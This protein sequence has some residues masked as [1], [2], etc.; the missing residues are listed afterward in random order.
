[1]FDLTQDEVRR[2]REMEVQAYPS[3]PLVYHRSFG[4]SP[5][6]VAL[7]VAA[8]RTFRVTHV[9]RLSHQRW[10]GMRQGATLSG[11][12]LAVLVTNAHG[13]VDE[14]LLYQQRSGLSRADLLI[15]QPA[16]VLAHMATYLNLR[17]PTEVVMAPDLA[18]EV[19]RL[20]RQERPADGSSGAH[21]GG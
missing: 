12:W 13:W 6:A 18:R 3:R 19:A 7:H 2:A 16:D 20:A 21:S 1:M 14:V 10:H 8:A 17:H 4:L 15:T 11:P 5:A 9:A